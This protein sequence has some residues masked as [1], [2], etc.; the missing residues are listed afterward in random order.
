MVTDNAALRAVALGSE[1]IVAGLTS[2]GV[3]VEMS[4][5]SPAVVREI[6]E[7]VA[8]RGAAMLDAPGSGST[9]TVEQGQA[10]I[11]VGGGAPAL[12]RGPPPPTPQGPGGVTPGRPLGPPQAHKD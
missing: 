9:I 10:S 7:A 1:G 2:G 3:F 8:A 4:T 6:G 5:V 11:Q 12:G